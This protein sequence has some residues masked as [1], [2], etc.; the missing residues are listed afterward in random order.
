MTVFAYV[1]LATSLAYLYIP[2]FPSGRQTFEKKTETPVELRLGSVKDVAVLRSK[3]WF[4]FNAEA[5]KY[6]VPGARVVF[7]LDTL[8]RN[9][10]EQVWGLKW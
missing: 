4:A 5:D 8:K 10:S 7:H 3:K 2:L 1:L 9:K 6:I